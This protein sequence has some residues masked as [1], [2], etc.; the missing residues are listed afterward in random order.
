[1]QEKIEKQIEELRY[2]HVL[3]TDKRILEDYEFEA[4]KLKAL[5]ADEEKAIT[6]LQKADLH[7][8]KSAPLEAMLSIEIL[9]HIT[10]NS[11]GWSGQ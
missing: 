9:T 2:A 7:T 1:V 8:T 10:V 4:G 5:K 11:N 6:E 3:K